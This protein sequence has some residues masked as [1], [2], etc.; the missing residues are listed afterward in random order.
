MKGIVHRTSFKSLLLCKISW[1]KTR[2]LVFQKVLA[3]ILTDNTGKCFKQGQ[4]SGCRAAFKPFFHNFHSI[5]EGSSNP[6]FPSELSR[7]IG[8]SG[9]R[10]E[11][12]SP[13]CA[14]SLPRRAT[15]RNLRKS[16][17]PGTQGTHIWPCPHQE[18]HA[19]TMT[20]WRRGR[21]NTSSSRKRRS[22]VCLVPQETVCVGRFTTTIL[23]RS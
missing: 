5:I 18:G 6:S 8:E 21:K 10:Q 9:L 16:P 15:L 7:P 2:Y 22:F 11:S 3:Q 12:L 14:F 20:G 1:K 13:R 4:Q 19:A 17:D 23:I